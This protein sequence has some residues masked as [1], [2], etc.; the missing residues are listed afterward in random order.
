M[1]YFI[2]VLQ[3]KHNLWKWKLNGLF[4]IGDTATK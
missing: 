2:S 3:E 1:K 4:I